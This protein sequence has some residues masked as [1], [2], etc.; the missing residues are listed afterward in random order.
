MAFEYLHPGLIGW[1]DT[2]IPFYNAIAIFWGIVFSKTFLKTKSFTPRLNKL[3]N[4][5]TVYSGNNIIYRVR[6][7]VGETDPRKAKQGSV[8]Q[9]FSG[10]S[11]EIA[12]R[13]ARY[14]NNVIHASSNNEDA[15]RELRLWR[16]Y[17]K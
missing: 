15:E 4:I 13:E 14:L 1:N 3:L 9:I 6:R 12:A 2:S 8:R 16:E 17:I 11:L 10:D 7:A 5:L